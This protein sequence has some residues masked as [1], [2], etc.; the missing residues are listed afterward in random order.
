MVTIFKSVL[1]LFLLSYCNSYNMKKPVCNNC[2]LNILRPNN[3]GNKYCSKNDCKYGRNKYI[4]EVPHQEPLEDKKYIADQVADQVAEQVA[5]QVGDPTA[6]S[7]LKQEIE[8][9]IEEEITKLCE[10]IDSLID[11]IKIYR[12]NKIKKFIKKIYESVTEQLDEI[13]NILKT[14]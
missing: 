5:D 13:N 6:E 14:S 11:C 9:E 7:A 4:D 12:K 1:C 10:N 2:K 8:T 3:K